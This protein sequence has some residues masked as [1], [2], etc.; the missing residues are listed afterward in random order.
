MGTFWVTGTAWAGP[1]PEP[2]SDNNTEAVIDRY[3][4]ATQQQQDAL[5]GVSMPVEI[6]ASVPH[7][8]KSGTLNALRSISKL[9]KITYIPRAFFGDKSVEKEVIARYLSAEVQQAQDG[10]DISISPKNY[11][12]K[13]KG[14]EDMDGRQVYEFHLSP[15][16]KKVGLFKGELWIDAETFL[17]VRESGRFV[18]NPSIFFKKVEFTRTYDVSSGVAVPQ[19][20][21]SKVDT[22]LI[23]PVNLAISYGHVEKQTETA[24]GD[25]PQ[26]ATLTGAGAQ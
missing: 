2:G 6:D 24:T 1:S 18:K 19:R 11:K 15:R 23:G 25:A 21:E 14:M 13:Y 26:Q 12:F 8:K 16:H 5:R 7:L 4:A 22:R 3:M 9:G 17:P 10:P 20:M